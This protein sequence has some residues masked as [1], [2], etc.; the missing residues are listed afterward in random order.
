MSANHDV[1]GT[2]SVNAWE[3]NPESAV[4]TSRPVPDL[5]HKPLAF[6]FPKPA[7]AP[8]A[9]D[10]GTKQ[11]RYWPAAEALRRGAD[12]WAMLLP[13]NLGSPARPSL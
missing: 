12:F 11:F 6:S 5:S 4:Q 13:C 9:Y 3:D 1:H 8:G 10:P 2:S 7:P